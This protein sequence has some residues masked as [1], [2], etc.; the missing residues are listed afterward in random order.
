MHEIMCVCIHHIMCQVIHCKG[1]WL[2][3]G[4]RISNVQKNK[5]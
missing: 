3:L 4:V 2:L 5:K 1:A